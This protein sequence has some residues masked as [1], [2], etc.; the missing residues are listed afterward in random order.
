[1]NMLETVKQHAITTNKKLSVGRI[2]QLRSNMLAADMEDDEFIPQTRQLTSL[3]SL[4]IF[5]RDD[6]RPRRLDFEAHV[7]SSSY[8]AIFFPCQLRWE[9][10]P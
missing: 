4:W 7:I 5:S 2:D 6:I 1:M 3:F 9:R 10:A 8:L